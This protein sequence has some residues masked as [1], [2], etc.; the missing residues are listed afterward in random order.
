M[1]F[2]TDQKQLIFFEGKSKGPYDM[3][4]ADLTGTKPTKTLLTGTSW[5][6]FGVN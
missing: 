4:I 2:S 5:Y 3:R 1:E 6:L